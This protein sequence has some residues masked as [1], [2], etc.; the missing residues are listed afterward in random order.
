MN[1]PRDLNAFV[2]ELARKA[3]VANRAAYRRAKAKMEE[4]HARTMTPE[5]L[6]SRLFSATMYDLLM[7]TNDI[8]QDM[9]W[10][11]DL[12]A[13]GSSTVIYRWGANTV[14]PKVID[15]VFWRKPAPFTKPKGSLWRRK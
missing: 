9:V 5:A 2:E 3:K 7:S 6:R 13:H 15:P 12:A 4:R 1:E 8:L 10:L 11:D 14:E